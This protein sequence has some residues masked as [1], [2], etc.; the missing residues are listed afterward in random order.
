MTE[1]GDAIFEQALGG[2]LVLDAVCVS[3]VVVSEA[4]ILAFRDAVRLDDARGFLQQFVVFHDAASVVQA[5]VPEQATGRKLKTT[6]PGPSQTRRSD[7]ER[8]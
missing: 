3:G 2:A 1:A 5:R 7:C 4:K 6:S 8:A